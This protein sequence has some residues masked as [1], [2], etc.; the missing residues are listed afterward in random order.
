MDPKKI[1]KSKN[2]KYF[3]IFILVSFL[4]AGYLFFR[5]S[6]SKENVVLQIN[7]PKDASN[8]EEITWVVTI[9]NNSNIKINNVKLFVEYPL[10]IFNKEG[11]LKKREEIKIKEISSHEEESKSFS[12]IVFGKKNE[13]KELKTTLSYSPQGF[14]SEFQNEKS[15]ITIVTDSLINLNM[16]LPDRAEMGEEI[17]MSIFWQ[18]GFSFPLNNVQVRVTLP[19]GFKRISSPEETERGTFETEESKSQSKIIFDI[20]TLNEGEGQKKEIKGKLFGEVEDEKMFKVEIGKFDEEQ[21]EF[22][23]LDIAERSVKIVSSNIELSQKING[24]NEYFPIPGERLSYVVKFKNVGDDIYRNLDLEIELNGSY[25][26]L[27]SLKSQ[28][29]EIEGNK[30]KYSSETIP[31]LLYLGPY[32]QGSV[33]FS[34]NVKSGVLLQNSSIKDTIR[35]G[36]ITKSYIT[37][38]SSQSSFYQYAYYNLP[39]ELKGKIKTGGTFPIKENKETT[40]AIYLKAKNK[41]NRVENA[42]ITAVLPSNVTWTGKFYPASSKFSYNKNTRTVTLNLGSISYNFLEHYAFQVKIKPDN[43]PQDLILNSK[44]SGRDSWTRQSFEVLAPN[45]STESIE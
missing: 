36:R 41:G 21:Y 24:Q 11:E 7:A 31:E 15:F 4:L 39:K 5:N 26:D 13:K 43:I 22:I 1:F 44:L 30:I 23:P 18:S 12:G 40:L 19:E 29:G 28:G 14:S 32:D 6:F 10:G 33:G 3:L 42:K 35:V 17:T 34:V 9:K 16:K 20:G 2:F 45:L 38:I 37:K 27:S 25:L 8:G